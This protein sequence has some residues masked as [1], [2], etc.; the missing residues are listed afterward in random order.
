VHGCVDREKALELL[1]LAEKEI[2][3]AAVYAESDAR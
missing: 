3:A 2:S 1:E